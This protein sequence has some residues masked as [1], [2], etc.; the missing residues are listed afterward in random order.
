MP[1]VERALPDSVSEKVSRHAIC[2]VLLMR[3]K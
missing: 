3:E 1:A 2:P